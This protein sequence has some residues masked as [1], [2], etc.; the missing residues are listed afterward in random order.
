MR[1]QILTSSESFNLGFDPSYA[2]R[3]SL[4]FVKK[5]STLT[6]PSK[7]EFFEA[8]CRLKSPKKRSFDIFIQMDA[9]LFLNRCS[10]FFFLCQFLNL[11]INKIVHGMSDHV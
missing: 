7:T 9:E 3:W 8:Y 1:L 10:V 5:F 4:I 2:Y 11:D 6:I